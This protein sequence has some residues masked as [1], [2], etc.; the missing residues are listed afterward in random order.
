MAHRAT[1]GDLAA[2]LH[3]GRQFLDVARALATRMTV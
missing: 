1:G 3:R 2:Q